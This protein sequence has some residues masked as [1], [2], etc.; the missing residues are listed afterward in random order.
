MGLVSLC[1]RRAHVI[2]A[3]FSSGY[4]RCLSKSADPRGED[5]SCKVHIEDYYDFRESASY[6]SFAK[7]LIV[8]LTGTETMS[9]EALRA[10]R[11]RPR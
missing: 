11:S 7:E 6:L 2:S 10:E 8:E 3:V 5:V 9:K 4:T 1:D